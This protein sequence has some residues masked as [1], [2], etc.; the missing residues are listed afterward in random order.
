MMNENHQ[1]KYEWYKSFAREDIFGC[2]TCK[3]DSETVITQLEAKIALYRKAY[4]QAVET[5]WQGENVRLPDLD[6]MLAWIEEKDSADTND[7]HPH[8]SPR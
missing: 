5:A 2:K 7:R 1:C 3:T 4:E 6:E 8:S